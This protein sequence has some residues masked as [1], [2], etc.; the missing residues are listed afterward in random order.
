MGSVLWVLL[1]KRTPR[2][3]GV[4]D[5]HEMLYDPEMYEL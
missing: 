5:G 2:L 1:L 4:V 3:C